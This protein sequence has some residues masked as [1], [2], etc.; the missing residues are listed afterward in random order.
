MPEKTGN[1]SKRPLNAPSFMRP[2]RPVLDEPLEL[3]GTKRHAGA[4]DAT[5]EAPVAAPVNQAVIVEPPVVEPDPEPIEREPEPVE[6]NLPAEPIVAEPEPVAPEPVAPE[7]VAPEQAAEEAPVV[8]ADPITEALTADPEEL[9]TLLDQ[10]KK[11]DL[12]GKRKLSPFQSLIIVLLV[13]L[14][15]LVL[16]M[17]FLYTSGVIELPPV[18]MDVI[19]K[20]LDLVQ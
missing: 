1:N 12:R 19:D 8:G 10:L 4:L 16:A 5:D 2:R 13:V 17:V 6:D 20:G 18:M 3:D 14:V 7:P 15:I 11:S 9:Q